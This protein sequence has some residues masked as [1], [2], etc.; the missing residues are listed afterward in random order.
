MMVKGDWKI[1]QPPRSD[2]ML[3][4]LAQDPSESNDMAASEPDQLTA[5]VAE[6]NRYAEERNYIEVN[7]DSIQ[8]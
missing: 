2:W 8:P 7:A 5:L 3:F 6:F 4:N 1:V